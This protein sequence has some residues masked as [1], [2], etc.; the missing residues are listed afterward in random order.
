MIPVYIQKTGLKICLYYAEQPDIAAVG[1]LL[2]F[3]DNTVQHAGVVLGFRGTAD[4]IM[5]NYPLDCDGYAGSLV[6]AR[7][8]SAVTAACM[9]VKKSIFDS[10]GG[11]NE[12]YSNHIPGC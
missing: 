7:E 8:V 1:P 3:P 12:Y 11:F 2:I 10:V 6:C 4:H 9:M 5:R